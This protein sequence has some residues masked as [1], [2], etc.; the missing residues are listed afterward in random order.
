[1]PPDVPEPG[2]PAD[3]MRYARG[4]LSL[5][6]IPLPENSF[7]EFLC[8]H[9]QQAAEK[10]LKAV[11]IQNG[12]A[13]PKIH[14]IERLIDLLPKNLAKAP[15]LSEAAKLS[16][17]ATASRYPGDIS[18]PVTEEEYRNAVILAETVVQWAE[19]ILDLPKSKPKSESL[20]P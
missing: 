11:L 3:W 12:I 18:E 2:S 7:Y 14:I 9:T 16:V 15:E 1:M 10:S 19:T 6:Q 4:D 13:F 20:D 17:Y 8:F 5:A